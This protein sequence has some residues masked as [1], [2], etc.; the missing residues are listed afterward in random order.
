MQELP[1]GANHCDIKGGAGHNLGKVT[2]AGQLVGLPFGNGSGSEASNLGLGAGISTI[3]PSQRQ[4]LGRIAF[5][6]ALCNGFI[7]LWTRLGI[8]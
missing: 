4:L 5:S 2:G 1:D 8:T 3:F 7:R 6:L